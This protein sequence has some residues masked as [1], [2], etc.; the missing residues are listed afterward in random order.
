[1]DQLKNCGVGV[2]LS[3]DGDDEALLDIV[4]DDDVDWVYEEIVV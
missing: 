3:V 1:M 2:D 4:Y